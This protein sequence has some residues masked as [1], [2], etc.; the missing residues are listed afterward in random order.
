M[1]SDSKLK[2]KVPSPKKRNNVPS[3]YHTDSTKVEALKLWMVTG[4]LKAVSAAMNISY[5]TL[6]VWRYSDW[7]AEMVADIKNEGQIQ[8]SNRLKNIATKAMDVTLDRLENGDWIYDQKTGEMRRK[9]V[10]M[11]DAHRV[12]ESFVDRAVRIDAKP[13]DE[14][15]EQKVTDRLISLAETFAKF[16][17][18]KREAI[19]AVQVESTAE[20]P[21]FREARNGE[22]VGSEDTKHEV[23]AEQNHE[24][25]LRERQIT[26]L[27]GEQRAIYDQRQARLRQGSELGKNQ[28]ATPDQGSQEPSG[29][30]QEGGEEAGEGFTFQPAR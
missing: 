18:R 5:K 8:L 22:E 26:T 21:V 19:D 1:L 17:Q 3:A 10:A 27:I 7:W 4:N 9:P 30:P 29:E 20:I 24:E 6:Q 28:S 16:S 13:I 23:T 25:S 15:V 2:Q 11:R 14:V 12:A